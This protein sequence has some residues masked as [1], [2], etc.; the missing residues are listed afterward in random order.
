M[1]RSRKDQ[2]CP[3]L[4]IPPEIRV[5]I[6]HYLLLSRSCHL[7]LDS[8]GQENTGLNV[9]VLRTCRQVLREGL[10]VLYGKNV[11]EANFPI[12]KRESIFKHITSHGIQWIRRLSLPADNDID[13]I[14]ETRDLAKGAINSRL[15]GFFRD[16]RK[17][18]ANMQML[19]LKFEADFPPEPNE[20]DPYFEA[21]ALWAE[22]EDDK[23][24]DVR[25]RELCSQAREFAFKW[26]VLRAFEAVRRELAEL[27]D[28]YECWQPGETGSW[29]VFAKDDLKSA[30]EIRQETGFKLGMVRSHTTHCISASC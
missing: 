4:K 3:F 16:H 18:L 13:D 5:L 24:S 21:L 9:Q 14:E 11:L 27:V 23:V 2:P 10:P 6:L 15:A 19:R 25:R 1:A 12:D 30:R 7:S 29:V 22:Y 8:K 28:A 26:T 20:F 17:G